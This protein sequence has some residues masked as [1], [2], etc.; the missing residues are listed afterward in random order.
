MDFKTKISHL[1]DVA[2]NRQLGTNLD[3]RYRYHSC[4]WQ[5]TLNI[6]YSILEIFFQMTVIQMLSKKCL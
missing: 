4:Y 1:P 3:S 5:K 6:L 2:A